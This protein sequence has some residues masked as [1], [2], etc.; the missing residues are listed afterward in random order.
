VA[1]LE[2]STL[3]LR[4]AGSLCGINMHTIAVNRET[5]EIQ[6]IHNELAFPPFHLHS[7]CTQY[8]QYFS[9]MFIVLLQRAR[10][11]QEVVQIHFHKAP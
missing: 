9:H 10:V 6:A 5:E 7:E 4:Q 3:G 11:Y 8:T 1:R 2:F